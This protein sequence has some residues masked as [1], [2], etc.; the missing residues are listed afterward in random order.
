MKI[1]KWLGVFTRCRP[2]TPPTCASFGYTRC[3]GKD[4]GCGLRAT[5]CYD[6]I[7][8]MVIASIKGITKLALTFLVPGSSLILDFLTILNQ[9]ITLMTSVADFIVSRLRVAD[10]ILTMHPI[11]VNVWVKRTA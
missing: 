1:H 4:V 8:G 3:A 10:N 6:A 5:D 11:A 9:L 2:T 7:K